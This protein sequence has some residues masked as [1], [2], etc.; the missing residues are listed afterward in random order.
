MQSLRLTN[1]LIRTPVATGY[2][3]LLSSNRCRSIGS[4]HT[5]TRW[6]S[7]K[8]THNSV[9]SALNVSYRKIRSEAARV[10]KYRDWEQEAKGFDAN[11]H[12]IFDNPVYR[13]P[14]ECVGCFHRKS[15][16]ASST[17]TCLV[18]VPTRGRH[19]APGAPNSEIS[20]GL[21]YPYSGTQCAGISRV[22]LIPQYPDQPTR[23]RPGS[24]T[25]E[26][27]AAFQNNVPQY[28]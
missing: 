25:T 18:R 5:K 27:G 11:L 16:K 2:R 8:E 20:R 4:L 23:S 1:L 9:S 3:L 14:E 12:P 21:S 13:V 28:R 15:S 10:R 19:K 17:M 24:K 26:K 6:G 22:G 7:Q